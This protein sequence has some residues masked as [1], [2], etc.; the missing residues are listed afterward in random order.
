MLLSGLLDQAGRRL[1]TA[2][3][4]HDDLEADNRLDQVIQVRDQ[5]GILVVDGAPN[6]QDRKKAASF[7]LRNAFLPL[8]SDVVAAGKASP[9]HLEN[10]DLCVL[11][12]VALEPTKDQ[13]ESLSPEFVRRSARLSARA[14]A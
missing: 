7:F 4:E 14:A 9:R 13:P 6:E 10:K 2:T 3:V 11:V 12:N 8:P 1:V 5:V